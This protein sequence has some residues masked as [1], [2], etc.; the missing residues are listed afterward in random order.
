MAEAASVI[1]RSRIELSLFYD[2]VPLRLYDR[3]KDTPRYSLNQS[4]TEQ[5]EKELSNFR[6]RARSRVRI[7]ILPS[8]ARES[9]IRSYVTRFGLEVADAF[10]LAIARRFKCDFFVTRDNDFICK[11]KQLETITK[12][13]TPAHTLNMMRT[14]SGRASSP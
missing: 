7:R 11:K 6:K 5:I 2:G 14:H 12:I 4:Q 8:L 9:E 13:V 1:R 3:L 10:H